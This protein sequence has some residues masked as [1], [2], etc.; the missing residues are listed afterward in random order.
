MSK[1]CNHT[2]ILLKRNGTNQN[3]RH[4]DALS[5]DALKL[6]DLSIDDWMAFAHAFAKNVN[7]FDT[8]M[9]TKD[10]SWERFFVEKDAIKNF[11]LDAE[12]NKDLNPHLTL[13]VCFLKLI[14]LSQKRL[15]NLSKRH[16]DFYYKEV[17]K[18]SN[19]E[20]VPDKVHLLFE[21]AKNASDVRVEEE[22]A[23]DAGKDGDGNKRVYKTQNEL[24][25]N[26]AKIT[27]LKNVFHDKGTSVK[28][29]EIANSFDGLGEDFPDDNIKWWP[30]GH[31]NFKNSDDFPNLPNAKLGFAIAS[32]ILLLKEGERLIVFHITLATKPNKPISANDFEDG[33]EILLSGE[34]EWISAQIITAKSPVS[35]TD[36]S[37]LSDANL[38]IVV[39]LS[40][41]EEAVVPY[42]KEVL[43]ENFNSTNPIVR[44]LFKT[45][46]NT[47]G[48]KLYNILN[49]HSISKIKIDVDV[50]EMQDLVLENDLG[51]LDT[52][53]PF[54]PFGP[55]PV[56]NSKLY[57]GCQ[58]AL[59][60]PWSAVTINLQWKDTPFYGAGE[61]HFKEHYIAYRKGHLANLGK[62]TY[63][64]TTSNK[65][66]DLDGDL[67]VPSDD[68]FEV[69]VETLNEKTWDPNLPNEVLFVPS[70][71]GYVSN[72]SI[73]PSGKS[74]S[75]TSSKPSYNKTKKSAGDTSFGFGK[76][77]SSNV[78][79]DYS[80]VYNNSVLEFEDRIM[81]GVKGLF[82]NPLKQENFSSNSKRGFIRL[83]L[84]QS[85]L[86][87]LFPKIYAVALSKDVLDAL[88]PNEPY[89]PLAE[90]IRI[91][92]KA[93]VI[94]NFDLENTS[95]SLKQN[96]TN[97]L[98]ESIELFHEH[99]FGQS[100]QHTYLKSK[101]D[102]LTDKTQ[103][104][105]V[106]KCDHGELFIGLENAEQLQQI[107]FLIQVLEGSENP[108]YE[109]EETYQ[110]NEKLEWYILSGDEWK[111]LNDNFIVSN[112]TDNFLKSGI[113]KVSIPKEA[114]SN[115]NRIPGDLFW[116]KVT[117]IKAF[118]AVCQMVNI[119]TQAEIAEFYNNNN[120]LSHLETGL[121]EKTISKLVERIATLKGVTQPYS[122][123]D[124]V[125]KETDA[126]FY[127]R[128]SERLRHKQR[129]ITIWDYEQ[130]ILQQFPKIY[131]VNCLKHT[132]GDSELSPG[133]VTVI[134]VPNIIDQNVFDV[135]KPRISK[136]K[137]NEI[138]N[139]INSLNT[140]HVEALVENPKY[141]EVKISLKVKFY[142]GK[143]ENFYKKQLQKDISKFLAPWAYEETAEINF[144]LTLHESVVIYYIE[145]LDYVDYIKDFEL[146]EATKKTD[147][148]GDVIFN[149]VRAVVPANSKV[150][151]TSVKY[152]EHSVEPI[153]INECVNA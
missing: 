36:Y 94:K 117:N 33:L 139:F 74:S 131:K 29:S 37:T 59:N 41:A 79:S 143:D 17:L 67:I 136:A 44:F 119:H 61:D 144:G 97:Y 146:L 111:P 142:A 98:D 54:L 21:L 4:I 52:S 95:D 43:L 60:K 135:F 51:R 12:I 133:S 112:N 66:E 141:Q 38:K 64:L 145:Q 102:F 91:N 153:S 113:V 65:S 45:G 15:N 9:N 127:R 101:H 138:Q 20:A 50:K 62:N 56:R 28:Y 55:Q 116:L 105:L 81:E 125:P 110:D 78:F 70:S 148:K 126:Q 19:K 122:S 24:I 22:T 121:S 73:T 30:F 103:C 114:T 151:L 120:E 96:L 63:S 140:L 132:F 87:D 115:N 89:T 2:D 3:Q 57:I 149:P 58:E 108:D 84:Q 150:I 104:T 23:A 128:I 124:G 34:K 118:D 92:Y 53:K 99:P 68:Y 83:S 152:E 80:N 14:E 71:N 69:S 1:D 42:Q 31:P 82:N 130:L 40:A 129:A 32:P 147:S 26:S 7:Y 49:N 107:S 93:S 106:P 72:L 8:K 134:V 123:F 47:S 86:H 35:E 6:H 75:A 76:F 39:K 25:V 88:I 5:P 11:L 137:R 109:G 46:D 16:L 90:T 100:E 13:F 27:A 85:F 48:Y 77:R 18:L 10:G